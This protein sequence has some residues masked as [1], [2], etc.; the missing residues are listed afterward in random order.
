MT[1]TN[2]TQTRVRGVSRDYSEAARTETSMPVPP[3]STGATESAESAESYATGAQKK[4]IL[5][6]NGI[7]HSR[8]TTVTKPSRT[9]NFLRR[10]IPKPEPG[11]LGSQ[12]VVSHRGRRLSTS[13]E[14]SRLVRMGTVSVIC[15]IMGIMGAMSLSAASTQQTFQLQ[16]LQSQENLLDNQLE[17]LRRDL[18]LKR[19]A[20]SLVQFSGK[21]HLVIPAQPGVLEVLPNGEVHEIR[22][23]SDKILPL[24]DVNEAAIRAHAAS[25]DPNRTSEVNGSLA[26]VPQGLAVVPTDSDYAQLPYSTRAEQRAGT[27]EN[28][29]PAPAVENRAG[30]SAGA[31]ELAEAR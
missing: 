25:S 24:D 13:K 11:R 20:A 7:R 17:T 31:G 4:S 3:A 18:E 21:Q 28:G 26:P 19:S 5:G 23:P 22:P 10:T 2:P 9:A 27:A 12:Q 16:K 14:T 8:A 6:A 30:E 15:L 1:T 29:D